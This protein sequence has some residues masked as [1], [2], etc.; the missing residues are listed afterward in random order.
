VEEIGLEAGM[1]L[2]MI[3]DLVKMSESPVSLES[4]LGEEGEWHLQDLIEDKEAVSPPDAALTAMVRLAL[5]ETLES[6]R[7][8]ERRVVQLRFGIIDG[9][10]RTL[11]EIGRRLGLTRERIRQIEAK[12]LQKLRDPQVSS[13]LRSYLP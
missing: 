1:R 6:L 10:E 9:R 7:G 8:R 5:D 12:A 2:A 13:R 11:D 3:Q 4:P